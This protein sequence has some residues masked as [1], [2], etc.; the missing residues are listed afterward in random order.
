MTLVALLHLPM[1]HVNKCPFRHSSFHAGL[2]GL[3][4]YSDTRWAAFTADLHYIRR[5]LL[6]ASAT[7][8]DALRESRR[9]GAAPEGRR[10]L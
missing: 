7:D 3:Y 5:S 2:N 8:V 6:L 4:S 1:R 9:L 10:S